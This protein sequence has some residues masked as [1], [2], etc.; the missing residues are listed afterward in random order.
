MMTPP[1][2]PDGAGIW[3]S[4]GG[5]LALLLWLRR[6]LSRD[7]VEANRDKAE[8][9]LLAVLQE[10][11][12]LAR[13]GEAEARARE[14]E[15]WRARNADAKLIGELTAQVKHQS[16]II[17]HQSQTIASLEAQIN[18]LHNDVLALRALLDGRERA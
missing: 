6:Y 5:V 8:V 10:E 18:T 2:L 14:E 15:A 13:K 3:G 12:D 16:S 17:E 4:A 9:N 1:E 11:R 7:K